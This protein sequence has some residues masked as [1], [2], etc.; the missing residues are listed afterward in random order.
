MIYSPTVRCLWTAAGDQIGN[1]LS[2]AGTIHSNA[3]QLIDLREVCDLALYVSVAAA[4]GT[5][6]TLDVQV[7]VQDPSGNWFPQVVKTTQITTGPATQT[8]SVGLH[9][10]ATGAL[11]LPEY[12]RVT[13]TL[14]GTTPAYTGV[15]ITL[16]GR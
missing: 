7:D 8:A 5:I 11:V 16:Y 15:A 1:K 3:A 12:G 13:I 9:I 10:G 2:G 14:G 4:T 6:P